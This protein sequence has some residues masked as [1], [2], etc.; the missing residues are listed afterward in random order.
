VPIRELKDGHE[1]SCHL[2]IEALEEAEAHA[3]QILHG[4]EKVGDESTAKPIG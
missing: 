3:Q 2:S 1:I 4:F